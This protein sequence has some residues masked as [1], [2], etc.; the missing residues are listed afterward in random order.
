MNLLIFKLWL[1]ILLFFFGF[2][3][4]L[5]LLYIYESDY[6]DKFEIHLMKNFWTIKFH[7]THV[8]IYLFLLFNSPLP[9]A[10]NLFK[11]DNHLTL[12]SDEIQYNDH[13]DTRDTINFTKFKRVQVSIPQLVIYMLKRKIIVIYRSLL[14]S[15]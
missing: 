1:L 13:Y 15:R 12:K 11:L 6:L 14:K 4:T 2:K 7:W 3:L 9:N 10:F 8:K 5:C